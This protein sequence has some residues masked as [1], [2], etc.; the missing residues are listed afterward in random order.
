MHPFP[1]ETSVFAGVAL[2]T[3]LMFKRI[4]G[5]NEWIGVFN[6]GAADSGVAILNTAI[7]VGFGGVVKNTQGFADLVTALK[8][9]SMPPLVFVMITV[10]ICAGACGSASGGMGVAFN[11]LTDTYLALGAK[12]PYIHK[13]LLHADTV[14]QAYTFVESLERK[15]FD[16]RYAVYLYVVDL[17]TELDGLCFLA[18]YNAMIVAALLFVGR[19]GE[20]TSSGCCSTQSQ[21]EITPSGCCGNI[22][23]SDNA[24]EPSSCCGSPQPATCCPSETERNPSNSCC[25]N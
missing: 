20:T 25:G 2:A 14:L 11:A 21:T 24:E 17:R 8:G 3:I 19:R 9:M 12:L 22:E 5:V 16:E 7:V 1:V 10:A 15:M 6:K 18:S 4:K 13:L 23:N